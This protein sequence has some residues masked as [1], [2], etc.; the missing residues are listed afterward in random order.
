ML[1]AN[2]SRF[3]A[4]KLK[5]GKKIVNVGRSVPPQSASPILNRFAPQAK[6]LGLF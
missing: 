6:R 4:Q 5:E 1:L 3:T 2:L